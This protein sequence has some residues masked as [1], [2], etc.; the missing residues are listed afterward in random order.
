MLSGKL[1]GSVREVISAGQ[2]AAPGTF[3]THG[4]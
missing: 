3:R 2:L 1:I 4:G